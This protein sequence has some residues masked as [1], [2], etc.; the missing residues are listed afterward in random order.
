MP[1]GWYFFQNLNNLIFVK[2]ISV[3]SDGGL[4]LDC[5]YNVTMV[6]I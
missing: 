2:E 4:C 5:S 3:K 1:G 6:Y